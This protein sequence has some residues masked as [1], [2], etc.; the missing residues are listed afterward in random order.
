MTAGF[1]EVCPQNT[2]LIGWKKCRGNVIVKLQIDKKTKKS[3]G[4]TRGC[5]CEKARVLEVYG[6]RIG[7]SLHDYSFKYKK[8]QIVSVNN[9]D[10]NRWN[11]CSFGIH[12]FLT[13]EEAEEYGA[14]R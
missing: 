10:E 5:R 13:R 3:S 2:P 6:D 14:T 11:N 7:R 9:F 8:G 4:T 12:F 1:F